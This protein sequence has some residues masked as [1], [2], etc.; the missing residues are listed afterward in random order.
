MDVGE[1]MPDFTAT[2][3][4]GSRT[5]LSEMVRDG[6]AVLFFYPKAFTRG[7][8]AEAC[9]FRDL[10]SEFEQVGAKRFGVSTDDVDTQSRFRDTHGF[11]YPLIADPSGEIASIF[12]IA[13]RGPLPPK[14]QTFVIGT[15]R[16]LI[17]AIRSETN[18]QQHADEALRVLRSSPAP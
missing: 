6:P 18:M 5:T 8:T 3:D 13:R 9:H 4:D 16:R 1:Q 10:A 15:G 14:R 2:L 12:G 7:C 17:H 11:D